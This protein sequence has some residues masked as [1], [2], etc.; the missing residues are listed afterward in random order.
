MESH[1]FSASW[2]GI[3]AQAMVMFLFLMALAVGLA[4][5]L[6]LAWHLYLVLTG[7]T[8][9]GFYYNRYRAHVAKKRGE[10]YHNE[11]DLGYR[12]NWQF[13]FG[14]GRFWFS[15]LLPTLDPPPGNGINYPTCR[16]ASWRARVEHMQE[17][18]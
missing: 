17:L 18:V 10:V 8:T 16:T 7:Q 15:W 14:R 1:H 5:G 9:I 2:F 11:Y 12:A 13:F 4:V 3:S 6:M